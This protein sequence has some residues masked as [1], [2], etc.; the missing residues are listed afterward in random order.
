MAMSQEKQYSMSQAFGEFEEEGEEVL[1]ADSV[2]VAPSEVIDDIPPPPSPPSAETSSSMAAA[3]GAFEDSYEEEE[4]EEGE[5][6][7]PPKTPS[8]SPESFNK[9]IDLIKN[10]LTVALK[11]K[12]NTDNVKVVANSKKRSLK[13]Q[14]A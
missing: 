6:K 5:V 2:A 12:Y 7:P 10:E 1:S 13:E 9:N 4:E 14:I 8:F 11:N 3:F